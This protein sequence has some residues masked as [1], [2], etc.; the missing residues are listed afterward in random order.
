MMA[1][2]LAIL[3]TIGVLYGGSTSSS[4]GDIAANSEIETRHTRKMA[5]PSAPLVGDILTV[6]ASVGY[7]F[8]QVLYKKYAALP[9]DPELASEGLYEQIPTS[10]GGSSDGL[11]D[12]TDNIIITDSEMD[13]PPPLPPFGFHPNMLTS[14]IGLC[15]FI[16]LWIPIPIL[17]YFDLE[18]FRFPANSLTVIAIAGIAF[19]GVIFNAGF[20]ASLPSYMLRSCL[21]LCFFFFSN[22]EDPSRRLGSYHHICG[23]FAYHRSRILLGR[24][25]WRWYRGG[26]CLG[27]GRINCYRC[28]LCGVGV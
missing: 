7:A 5:K 27:L 12:E 25:V 3:G 11:Y 14:A 9:S 4:S 1:V 23:E 28:S 20:M 16:I 10:N 18:P 17:H 19:T 24:F 22:L 8:Y 21:R 6:V 26:Y 13:V 15:T 2:S